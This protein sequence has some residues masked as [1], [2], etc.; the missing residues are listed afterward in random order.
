M[1]TQYL[2]LQ[3]TNQ[4]SP[5]FL[6][7]INQKDSLKPFYDTFPTAENFEQLI[8][9]RAFDQAHRQIL[10]QVLQQQYARL[11]SP[12]V[13]Q[14][15]D[16]LQ[17]P[18]TFTV[19]T[20]HQLN[21][22]SGPLYVIYKL[23]TTINLAAQLQKQYPDYHFVPVY[24]MATED[25][26]F[27]EVNHF[28]L[29]GKK[30]VWE[31]TQTGA[32]GRMNPQ[33][34]QTIIAQLTD[35]FP[36]FEQAYLQSDTLAD[37]TR[38]WVTELFGEHG[39]VCLDA[40]DPQLK[41]QF[42][43]VMQA[44]LFDQ[45]TH[46]TVTDTSHRLEAL[47]YKTQV[48]PRETNFFYLDK[49][50][51]ERLVN[52][53]GRFRV[54]NTELTFS[55]EDMARLI[56]ENPEKLSPNVLLRP[57]YQEVVLPNL[58]Y[59]G[60]PSEIAYWLQLKDLFGALQTPF[61]VLMPRNFALVLTAG[62]NKKLE[63]TRLVA[64]DLFLDEVALKRKYVETT[65]TEPVSLATEMQGLAHIFDT[66]LQKATTLDKS[67]EG[68]VGAERQKTKTSLENIEK[69]LRKAEEQKQEVG[70][71]QV[72]SLKSKLFP[73]GSLQ[74][75]TDNFLNFYANNPSFLQQLHEQFDPFRFEFQILTE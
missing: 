42:K 28:H 35:K 71:Q 66:I 47:G 17:Q 7:Y 56:E 61:P 23:V 27:E 19:T 11:H 31:T 39:L 13:S 26:D 38:C 70:I 54:L 33:E 25:H 53:H 74:E 10:H 58:A 29:F 34:M 67:L 49:K 37:A 44:D 68:F 2:P 16:S 73:D 63:K 57:V 48:N 9:N 21:I 15:I 5:L 65:V 3:Q 60:G 1:T 14:Q 52:N 8:Q 40:D 62:M 41:A 18:N 75:R 45:L 55:K 32:V 22:F 46:K 6:D 64:D 12:T 4:F 50:M 69:R 43:P 20:G 30:H 72:M 24:W 36:V 51:R 59:I